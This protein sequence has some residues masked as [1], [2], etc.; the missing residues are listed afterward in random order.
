MTQLPDKPTYSLPRAKEIIAALDAKEGSWSNMLSKDVPF[1]VVGF[2]TEA[3]KR[4]NDL[5]Q[6]RC[7]LGFRSPN[8]VRWK[9]VMTAI[10]SS[11]RIDATG[12]FLKWMERNEIWGDRLEKM[13]VEMVE[14]KSHLSKTVLAALQQ[15]GNLQ[16][17]TVKLGKELGV[18]ADPGEKGGGGQGVTIVVTTNVPVPDQNTI[19]IHQEEHRQKSQA[20][21][22]ENRP[23]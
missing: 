14:N 17:N 1:E 8:D 15:I 9:K 12:I 20:L 21:L 13:L 16:I 2:V 23:K 5:D 6:I 4:G 3:A 11:K 18:F 22:D 7:A 10:R 19:E